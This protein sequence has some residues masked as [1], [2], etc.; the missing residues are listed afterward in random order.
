MILFVDVMFEKT[1]PSGP[2]IVAERRF[3]AV[4]GEPFQQTIVTII[5]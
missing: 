5:K 1:G 3:Q 4:D 2:E